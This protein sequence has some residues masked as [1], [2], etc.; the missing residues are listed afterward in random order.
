M[1]ICP[2]TPKCPLFNGNLLKRQESAETY[3]NLYCRSTTKY[4]ECKRYIV[5]E[6]TGKCP[7]WLLP[8]SSYQMEE[9]LTRM[10]K[11]GLIA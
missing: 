10:K 3:K 6:K 9:I 7:N 5:S 2:K 1:D 4:K 11:E 8:N